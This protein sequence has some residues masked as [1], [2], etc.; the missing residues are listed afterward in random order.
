[1]EGKDSKVEENAGVDKEYRKLCRGLGYIVGS[2]VSRTLGGW[3]WGLRVT[4]IM[5]LLAVLLM[6]LF[7]ENP[8]RGKAPG[9]ADG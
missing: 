6:L 1:M 8:R 3:N 5:V 4:P 2:A 7:L 9:R